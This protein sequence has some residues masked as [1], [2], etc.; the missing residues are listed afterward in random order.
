MQALNEF[1]TIHIIG[2]DQRELAGERFDQREV[3]AEHFVTL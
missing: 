1:S 3:A 2:F